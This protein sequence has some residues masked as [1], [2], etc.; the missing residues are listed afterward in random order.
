ME[1]S[2]S[3]TFVEGWALINRDLPSWKESSHRLDRNTFEYY[4]AY[5]ELNIEAEIM[6]TT[7]ELSADLIAAL[8]ALAVKKGYRG[9]SKIMEEAVK[10]YLLDHE[11]KERSWSVLMKMRGS[12]NAEEAAETKKRLEEIRKNWRD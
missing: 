11:K 4:N 10:R 3:L 7:I 2:M 6:R 9:Y 8:H 12:W 1:I 5:N